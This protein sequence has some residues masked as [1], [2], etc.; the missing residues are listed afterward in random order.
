MRT[1][2]PTLSLRIDFPNGLRFGPGK[3]ALLQQLTETGSITAAAKALNMSYPR[4]L[5]L[6]EQMNETFAGSVIETKTGGAAGGGAQVTE[7][8]A[9]ILALYTSLCDGALEY[10]RD[11]L[12]AFDQFLEN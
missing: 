2:R 5:K 12:T 4:A 7:L 3:A 6:I 11:A 8:G 10:G 9:Q 1:Q